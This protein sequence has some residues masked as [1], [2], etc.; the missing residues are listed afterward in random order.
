MY[1]Q[2]SQWDSKIAIVPV[3]NGVHL[4]P[5]VTGKMASSASAKRQFFAAEDAGISFV[6][7]QTKENSLE[8]FT[9]NDAVVY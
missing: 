4:V 9:A 7:V 3:P 1:T 6:C 8:K 5:M 2:K